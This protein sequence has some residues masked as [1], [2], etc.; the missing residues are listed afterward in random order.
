MKRVIGGKAYNT[1]TA[2]KLC[3]LDGPDNRGDFSFHDTA[4]YVTRGGAYF[5]A[6][7]GGPRSMWARSMSNGEWCGG[8]GVRPVSAQE[9]AEILAREG[10]VETLERLFGPTEEAADPAA[11]DPALLVRMTPVL[12]GLV[13]DAARAAGVPVNA[14]VLQAIRAK[15]DR[16]GGAARA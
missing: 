8:E 11:K 12:K 9:A 16:E 3:E 4:L 1:E 5:L 7:Y 15:L 13:A 14:W 2:T 6:G 10:E